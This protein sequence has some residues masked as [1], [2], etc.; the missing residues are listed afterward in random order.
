MTNALKKSRILAFVLT[1]FEIGVFSAALIFYLLD[2]PS[3]FHSLI[4]P[5]HWAI[6]AGIVIF[7]NIL[8]VAIM[9]LHIS[10]IRQ[11]SDLKAA[12]IIG[13][14]VQE[15]YN[16]GEIGLVVTD[17]DDIVIWSNVIFKDRSID[18][19]DRNII[20]WQEDLR[21]LKDGNSDMTVRI[22]VDSKTYEVKYLAEAH[23]YIF[24]DVTD[25]TT[26]TN[27]EKEHSMVIGQIIIDNFSEIVGNSEDENN[28]IVS[29]VRSAI[30][31]YG[32]AFNV[33]IRR[34]RAD[35]YF[36][37]CTY[38]ALQKMEADKFSVMEKAR[39]IGKGTD[40]IPTLSI[41][42][43][44][45]FED[46]EKLHDMASQAINIAMSRG[47]DQAVVSEYNKELKFYGGKTQAAES[48]SKVKVRN[49]ADGLIGMIRQAKSIMVMG[50]AMADM[51]AMGACLGVMAIA[52]YCQVPCRIIYDPKN[53]ETKTRYAFQGSFTKAEV[54]KM[55]ID[56]KDA[57]DRINEN[58][59]LVVVDVS[60]PQNTHAPKVLDKSTKTVVIDHHRMG[61]SFIDQ[62][63]L[64]YIEPSASSASEILAELIHYATANPRIELKPA[65]AT[66]ML[67]GMFLDTNFFK[68][69]STG[70]RTFDAAEL[71][72]TYGADNSLAD[73]FLK[74]EYEEYSLTTKIVSTMR[75]PYYGVV[76]C[77][78]D[79]HDI[80]ESAAISKVANQLMQLKG[81]NASFV[82]GR[83]QEKEIKVSCRSDATIN[84]QLLAEKMH[85]DGGGGHFSM[86]AAVFKNQT[87]AGVEA[88][89]LDTL[90]QY[91]NE[92]RNTGVREEAR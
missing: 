58:T 52:D 11:R 55:T 42:F 76:Y 56:P 40:T 61:A 50:H 18:L 22:F 33:V 62:N 92:A 26:L 49:F 80:I 65:F 6:L 77:V 14:D 48:T 82:I 13:S 43:A 19:L 23:L 72:K 8:F 32:K 12:D 78:A 17:N 35:S 59:L 28:D 15:A 51:D 67:A 27:Y 31:D 36:A 73:D 4:Q 70:A 5:V 1:L 16:F 79:D 84:V 47:G 34:F 25:F 86:A 60:V 10:N 39:A 53:T 54:E 24:K 41:G 38:Q 9:L 66:L 89:L 75:T 64:N 29:R 85:G 74:D 45:D 87:V 68:S 21:E 2:I 71:L 20:E 46:P 88:I 83:T 81:I 30:F 37:V 44:H 63:V 91:L 90:S 57:L 7:M 69:K 3:G